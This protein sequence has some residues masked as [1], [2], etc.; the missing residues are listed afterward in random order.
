M[1]LL[2]YL[3]FLTVNDERLS[4]EEKAELIGK[5]CEEYKS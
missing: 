2:E 1:S 4:A 3:I 5:F